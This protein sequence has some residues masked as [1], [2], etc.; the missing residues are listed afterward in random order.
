MTMLVVAEQYN[1]RVS[2]TALDEWMKT[3]QMSPNYTVEVVGRG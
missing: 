3:R 2:I 1:D